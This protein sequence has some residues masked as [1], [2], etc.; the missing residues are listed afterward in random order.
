[1][2]KI[3]PSEGLIFER[4]INVFGFCFDISYKVFVL[5]FL[6][7]S[8]RRQTYFSV[9]DMKKNCKGCFFLTVSITS[10]LR[11][12]QKSKLVYQNFKFVIERKWS[13]VR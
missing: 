8:G 12:T 11:K 10:M 3:S 9:Y 13:N 5:T 6:I 1:M 4:Q 7:K 2:R